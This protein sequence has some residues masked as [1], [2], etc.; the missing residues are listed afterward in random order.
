MNID[1]KAFTNEFYQKQTGGKLDVVLNN[2]K[3]L[4]SKGVHIELTTLII[5]GLNDSLIELESYFS[6]IVENLSN[7]VPIHLSAYH[8]DYKM[9]DIPRTSP[10][11]LFELR[12]LALKLSIKN[13]HLGN[14]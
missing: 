5:P 1:L 14:I 9:L 12:D 7:E 4:Y 13:V 3:Y 6:W 2:I 11:I 10:D 8:P